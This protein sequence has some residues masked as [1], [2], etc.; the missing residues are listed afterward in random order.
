M[1]GHHRQPDKGAL[2]PRAVRFFNIDF[3]TVLLLTLWL[4]P[5]GA[6]LVINRENAF[7][8]W[9]A[10]AKN[11][12]AVDEAKAAD[13]DRTVAARLLWIDPANPQQSLIL[14]GNAQGLALY[15]LRGDKIYQESNEAV[16]TLAI[17]DH[18]QLG[19]QQ[20]TL[21][22]VGRTATKEIEI[23]QLPANFSVPQKVT[24]DPLSLASEPIALCT[25]QSPLTAQAYFFVALA[26]ETVEQ[27]ALTATEDQHI[28]ATQVQRFKE[29][30]LVQS[31]VADDEFA[32]VYFAEAN[33]ELWKY[34]AEPDR[35]DEPF[36]VAGAAT[37]AQL[38][39][40][41]ANLRLTYG[42]HGVGYLLAANTDDTTF[43]L[44]DRLGNNS[45][46]TQVRLDGQV[47]QDP[48]SAVQQ[49]AR[50]EATTATPELAELFLRTTTHAADGSPLAAAVAWSQV[51]DGAD[52]PL[53]KSVQ[54]AYTQTDPRAQA[55][56]AANQP[57]GYLTTPTELKEIKHKA[58]L[59]I[60]PYHS[61]VSAVLA[62]ADKAWDFTLKNKET[63][64]SADKPFWNDNTHGT[65]ILYAKALA[66][67]M[68]G[69]VHYAKDVKTILEAIMTNVERISENVARCR[70]T[71]SWGTPE[72][73]AAADLIADYWDN[74][75]CTGPIATTYK[76]ITIE[77]GN[78][79][80]LFQNW[81]IK[82]PYYI[83]SYAAVHSQNNWGAAAANTTAYIADYV[84][85][86]DNVWL[87]HRNPNS[88]HS[89]E[90]FVMLPQEAYDYANTLTLA[91]INGYALDQGG[92]VSCD[93]L[94]GEQNPKWPPVKSQ[95][96]EKGIIPEEA[97]RE[98]SCNI[99]VYNGSYQN[100]P[101]LHLGHTIQQCELML[102]RGDRTCYDNMDNSDLAAFVYVDNHGQSHNTHLYPGRGS[103]E[104]AINAVIVDSG[105]EWRHDSALAVAYRYY[106]QHHRF[107][108]V[109]QWRPQIDRTDD[110]A[111]D[112]CFGVLTHGLA[113]DETPTL[114]PVTPLGTGD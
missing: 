86:R 29:H 43:L 23:Y 25:Y 78:C 94:A 70:L 47:G 24:V 113:P 22:L 90:P 16:N 33:G 50:A 52:R 1:S 53:A 15:N 54:W 112:I 31:C 64:S 84:S 58:A 12:P 60:E 74:L 66:Y 111:Q 80:T 28:T 103:I 11:N 75:Q 35:D 100:Y 13:L 42:A 10:E 39:D 41:V 38:P 73:V 71:F 61:A 87:V 57:R 79:K 83:V 32:H 34:S 48:W 109:A 108:G 49:Q 30:G 56:P 20:T 92:T 27:W 18:F 37:L 93:D 89:G 105:T 102:R 101:Q 51:A 82:N 45:Y 65:P 69:D 44:Y 63:C 17:H 91:R 26:N 107:T 98:E 114:P 3:I 36:Q 104:R 85:D 8:A 96:T 81:L 6:S 97:R 99:P 59:G 4:A 5:L 46:V 67:Q 76:D 77:T 95:I 106:S 21:V 72:L 14:E 2:R 55:A 40:G 7:H 88:V 68:T 62:M 19:Q 110:C 9:L